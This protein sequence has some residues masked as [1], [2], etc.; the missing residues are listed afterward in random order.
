MFRISFAVRKKLQRTPGIHSTS[1]YTLSYYV[2]MYG[3]DHCNKPSL[4]QILAKTG[5]MQ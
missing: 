4:I 3:A 5:L 1:N 2:T